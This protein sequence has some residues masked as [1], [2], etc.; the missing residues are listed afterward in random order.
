MILIGLIFMFA[1]LG[2]GSSQDD[3]C[4]S[5][6]SRDR[7]RRN[8]GCYW[9]DNECSA[10][11]KGIWY[12]REGSQAGGVDKI[13]HIYGAVTDE[14]I[15]PVLMINHGRGGNADR[16]RDRALQYV[17]QGYLVVTPSIGEF[18]ATNAA[19]NW[20]A[21]NIRQ[22]GGDMNSFSCHGY[23]AGGFRCTDLAL[24]KTRNGNHDFFKAAVILSGAPN[25]ICGKAHVNAPPFLFIHAENDPTVSVSN[26]HKCLRDF[27]RVEA[28]NQPETA[29]Y[30]TGRHWVNTGASKAVA[31]DFLHRHVFSEGDDSYDAGDD[32]TD[33]DANG[34]SDQ[35]DDVEDPEQIDENVS[36]DS[37][38]VW[39]LLAQTSGGDNGCLT[40]G[41]IQARGGASLEECQA[42]CTSVGAKFLQSHAGGWCSCFESCTLSR[43]A[44]AYNSPADVY[45]LKEVLPEV[46]D[47]SMLVDYNART[48][49]KMMRIY[50]EDPNQDLK[51][52]VL[53]I[54][55]KDTFDELCASF[56]SEGFVV[57]CPTWNS[58]HDVRAAINFAKRNVQSFGGDASRFGLYSFDSATSH[59]LREVMRLDSTLFE[60]LVFNLGITNSSV[61]RVRQSVAPTLVIGSRNQQ[62]RY[63]D[64]QD[65]LEAQN[66]E[67]D[68]MFDNDFSA[69][70]LRQAVHS[71]FVDEL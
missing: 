9:F 37:D 59:A 63:V 40:Q 54:S 58:Y 56:A 41:Q 23:S 45:E 69:D 17:E 34:D 1:F 2:S 29:I 66:I 11:I 3:V 42:I 21:N 16:L 62:S 5:I 39:E 46:E 28:V 10:V 51:R 26:V 38:L 67:V 53:V 52:A 64:F 57:M 24:S 31:D 35:T 22:Y 48:E 30:S 20:I 4:A 6:P 68:L 8:N 33:D 7:C 60:A 55:G 50:P 27:E 18:R 14:G 71:F 43:P 15:K 65:A 61:N 32:Q 47:A 44:S 25:G 36:S 19:F 49:G 13:L 12:G 70:D